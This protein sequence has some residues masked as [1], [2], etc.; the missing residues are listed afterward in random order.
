MKPSGQGAL[1]ALNVKQIHTLK[2][3]FA[4]DRYPG[5]WRLAGV[6]LHTHPPPL[7]WGH[8]D[9]D[10]TLRVVTMLDSG[11]YISDIASR[12]G[13]GRQALGQRLRDR[14]IRTTAVKPVTPLQIG[15]LQKLRDFGIGLSD[16]AALVFEHTGKVVS[17]S[18]I[19]KHTTKA[20]VSR[21]QITL[22]VS[23]QCCDALNKL[24]QQL[25]IPPGRALEAL[26]LE[27]KMHTVTDEVDDA[28]E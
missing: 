25:S 22:T 28:E 5:P 21:V 6:P 14:G 20:K 1:F 8:S 7:C 23:T 15:A 10:C 13:M 26:V 17:L 24:A 27:H 4:E 12:Y 2:L 3:A 18:T 11:V 16:I 9:K 19:S